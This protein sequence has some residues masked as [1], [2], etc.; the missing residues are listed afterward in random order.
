[1][2]GTLWRN[3]SRS[4]SSSIRSAAEL[5]GRRGRPRRLRRRRGSP[6]STSTCQHD[7]VDLGRLDG[8]EELG[9]TER[10]QHPPGEPASPRRDRRPAPPPGRGRP[11]PRRRGRPARAARPPPGRRAAVRPLPRTGHAPGGRI[12][13]RPAPSPPPSAT[14]PGGRGTRPGRR[15]RGPRRGAPGWRP[16]GPSRAGRRWTR[17]R[18]RPRASTPAPCRGL[19]PPP[20][21]SPARRSISPRIVYAVA[22]PSWS[23]SS[24]HSSSPRLIRRRPS[25]SSPCWTTIAA[26]LLTTTASRYR[27]PEA[28]TIGRARSRFSRA[29][30]NRPSLNSTDRQLDEGDRLA[31]L[32][33]VLA[34]DGEDVGEQLPRPAELADVAGDDGEVAERLAEHPSLVPRSGTGHGSVERFPSLLVPAFPRQALAQ[35]QASLRL[36]VVEA[37]RPGELDRLQRGRLLGACTRCGGTSNDSG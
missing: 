8:A 27:N 2:T 29:S 17:R 12:P 28:T 15:G 36:E 14:R 9:A 3:E 31:L 5:S 34:V 25:P 23:S 37:G 4:S 22:T 33:V 7:Q 24:M 20:S 32:V 6:Q 13:D 10:R 21:K 30:A 16:R 11:R 18:S 1:M 26:R 19:V 35:P